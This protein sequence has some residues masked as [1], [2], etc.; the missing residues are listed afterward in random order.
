MRVYTDKGV[1]LFLRTEFLNHL[2]LD[3]GPVSECFELCDLPL[4][5]AL[6]GKRTKKFSHLIFRRGFNYEGPSESTDGDA[7]RTD[8]AILP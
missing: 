2:L 5:D 8:L 7:S 3:V 4:H 6:G 1:S